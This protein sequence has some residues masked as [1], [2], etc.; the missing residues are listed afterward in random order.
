MVT[1]Q[2]YQRDSAIDAAS[3]DRDPENRW[4]ARGSRFRL[5]SWMIRDSALA[6]SGLLNDA[7]G[8]PPVYPYQP[9]GVWKDQFMGR[10]EYKP[11]VGPAQ[12]RRTLYAFWRRT[13]A[14]TF[15][16]DSAMRRTCEVVQRRT[17]TPLHALTL[18]NDTTALEAARALAERG[19]AERGL[20]ESDQDPD[21]VTRFVFRRVLGRPASQQEAAV[22]RQ[23]Y[24]RS[25]EHYRKHPDQAEQ[26]VRVGQQQSV[27][28]TG[29]ADL[30]AVMLVANMVL[31]L[32]EAITHE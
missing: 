9:V 11:S 2:A 7:V 20:R 25:L 24:D 8:G 18:L 30:A 13:S 32:D 1:S 26:L 4:L 5:P 21:H 22:L 27:P 28:A 12:Y 6:A 23:H 15:L 3:L 10:F 29:L 31:N 16:F 19:L 17:N 14:P